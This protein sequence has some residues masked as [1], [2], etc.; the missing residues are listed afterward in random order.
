METGKTAPDNT[1]YFA[2]L[3][4]NAGIEAIEN[5]GNQMVPSD[6]LFNHYERL[7]D[8]L[9]GATSGQTKVA[10]EAFAKV[11]TDNGYNL[12]WE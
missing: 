2:I 4:R 8:R 7:E 1:R 9:V 5:V 12:P 3:G 10:V 11:I 6:I